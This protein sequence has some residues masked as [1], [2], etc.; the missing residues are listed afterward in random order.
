[1]L[2]MLNVHDNKFTIVY[3]Q[4]QEKNPNWILM[5]LVSFLCQGPVG[6]VGARGDP[7]SEGPMVSKHC[8]SHYIITLQL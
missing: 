7:G 6:P 8:N 5:F 2:C 4:S 1:M 3:K